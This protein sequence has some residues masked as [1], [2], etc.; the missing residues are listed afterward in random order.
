MKGFLIL[1]SIGVLIS[2]TFI[3]VAVFIEKKYDDNHPVKKWWRK[4]VIGEAPPNVDL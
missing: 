2:V 1:Y 3:G 4:H